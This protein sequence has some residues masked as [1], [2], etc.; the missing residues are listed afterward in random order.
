MTPQIRALVVDDEPVAR[1]A[2]R[3]LLSEVSWITWIGEAADGFEAI[4]AIREHD[5]DLVFLDV[6]MPGLNGIQV[7]E[8]SERE[9]AVVFTTAHDDYAMAAF[10][11]GAIDYLRKPFGRERF[12]RALD[13]A[14]AQLDAAR[15]RHSEVN[16]VPLGQRL[17]YAQTET[18]TLRRI[19]VRDRG[20]IIPV[21]M[22][23]VLRF[24]SDGDYVAVFTGG[25]RHL[26]YVNLSDLATRLD[27]E[28]FIRVHRSHIVNLDRVAAMTAHD[29]SRLE[30]QMQD[31][32][33]IVASRAG[34]TE[35][36][37]RF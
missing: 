30:V 26:V 33:R 17:A 19:F 16:D 28:R 13:R 18:Q 24:E 20:N 8:Q 14:R 12:L 36:R 10:E 4:A 1:T 29:A 34:T 5:P 31:G 23:D 9:P 35:L 22:Q 25:R 11:L 2:L 32:S 27:P 3:E 21:R 7:L 37:K 15:T 6:Q